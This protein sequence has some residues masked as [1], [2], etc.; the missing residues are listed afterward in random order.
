MAITASSL[1]Q[2]FLKLVHVSQKSDLKAI[3]LAQS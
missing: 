2:N 1:T 3:V